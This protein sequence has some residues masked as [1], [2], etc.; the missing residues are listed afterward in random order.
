MN[1]VET[2]C[3]SQSGLALFLKALKSTSFLEVSNFHE[4]KGPDSCV[5]ARFRLGCERQLLFL[6]LFI[7]RVSMNPIMAMCD[8]TR[9]AVVLLMKW[10]CH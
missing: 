8:P 4:T 10:K 6:A 5:F 2:N 3:E 7:P 9:S 1:S